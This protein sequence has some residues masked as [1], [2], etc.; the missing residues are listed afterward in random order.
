MSAL[1]FISEL[2][3]KRLIVSWFAVIPLTQ[4]SVN[5]AHESAICGCG[6]FKDA[7]V[8]HQTRFWV[9]NVFQLLMLPDRDSGA[10]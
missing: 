3:I 5:D 1:T 9:V 4:R 6:P 10:V 2:F 7:S 8:T